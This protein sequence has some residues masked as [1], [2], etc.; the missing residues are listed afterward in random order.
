VLDVGAG[1]GRT[2]LAL[3]RAGHRVTALD[4]DPEL[5]EELRCRAA[6]LDLE[7]VLADAR[8]F[9][10]GRRFGLV[11]V[12]M[13]TIQLLGGRD[14]RARFLARA[15]EHL[16][17]GAV[18]AMALS[19]ELDEFD[20]LDGAAYPLPDVCERD[21]IV[22]SSRPTAVR[23]YGD[24]F[25]LERH[26]EVVTAAGDLETEV[27]V[28]RLDRLDPDELE[29]E[30]AALGLRPAGREVIPPTVEHVG[31]VVVMVGG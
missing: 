29:Q 19:D 4:N 7:A 21:G 31:S 25:V 26:R 12:P 28:I 20:V 5:L 23:D 15:R 27:N 13:Q 14:G 17:D 6:G 24:G 1:T 10:L 30:A 9:D 8:D 18:V 3:A 22:Y 2:A 16:R 11:V